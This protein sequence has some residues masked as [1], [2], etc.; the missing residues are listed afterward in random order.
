MSFLFVCILAKTCFFMLC[1]L[2]GMKWYIIVFLITWISLVTNVDDLFIW[3]LAICVSLERCWFRSFV[4]FVVVIVWLFAFLF[5]S[6]W[7]SFTYS[8]FKSLVRYMIWKYFLSFCA[9]YFHFI[10]GV[11]ENPKDFYLYMCLWKSYIVSLRLDTLILQ[12]V[13]IIPLL[14]SCPWKCKFK[15]NVYFLL[16][17]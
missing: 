5:L 17:I 10:D 14:N 15:Y 12:K 6:S 11:L 2:G 4:H 9:L 8:G 3:L 1:I 7:K 16:W 13:I